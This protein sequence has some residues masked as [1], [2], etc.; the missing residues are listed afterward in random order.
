M[1]SSV[2]G[3]VKSLENVEKIARRFCTSDTSLRAG[4]VLDDWNLCDQEKIH[5]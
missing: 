4:D 2:V 5:A 3:D 1:A